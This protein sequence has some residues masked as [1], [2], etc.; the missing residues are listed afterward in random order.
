MSKGTTMLTAAPVEARPKGVEMPTPS[1]SFDRHPVVLS[2][3]SAML[4]WFSFLPTDWS[5][6]AWG[7]LVPL[8]LLIRSPRSR[9]SIYFGAWTGGMLFW[10]LAI[11]WV[12]LTDSDAWLAWL[13]MALALSVWWPGF[14]ML[15]R[16][17]VLRLGLP[18]MVA[19]PPIWVGLEYVR[20]HIFTGF[21]WYYLAHTQH[22]MLPLIQIADTTGALGVSL[23]LA[24]VNAWL[25]DLRTLPLSRSTPQGN[26]LSRPQLVRAGIVLGTLAATVGYGTFRIA[27]ARFREGPRLAL[28]QS[29]LEQ[30]RK[31]SEEPDQILLI[32]KSL[33]ERALRENTDLDL[34]VWPETAYPK[35]FVTRDPELSD[36]N[37]ERHARAYDETKGRDFWE[38]WDLD[39]RFR[40]HGW[41]DRIKVPMLVG[42][43]IYD[44]QA[45]GLAKLNS[46]ILFQPGVKAIQRYAKMHLVPFGEYVP[47]IDVFPW[48]T[49]LTPYRGASV[50]RLAFGTQPTWFNLGRYRVATAICFEDTIPQAVRRFFRGQADRQPDVVLNISNDG[51]FQGSSE[52]DMHLAISVFRAIENRVPMARAVNMGITAFIDGNGRVVASLAKK[53]EGVLSGTVPLD[54]RVSHYSEWGDW[55]G[56]ICLTFTVALIPVW[57]LQSFLSRRPA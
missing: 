57:V 4:L 8:F 13:V 20:A 56:A 52:H 27:T 17:S 47:L 9:R 48:L 33:V 24:L 42:S 5:W 22:Q 36:S 31:R 50:P 16:F 14:L 46:A 35:L 51:W 25:V 12:S 28:L 10:V 38:S 37:Y 41:T 54:D 7:A 18:L 53:T 55:L 34:I 43:V 39:T 15:A 29:N 26:R 40:M 23:I 11:Q 6:L 2:F 45:S 30:S 21:S 32:Y 1:L 19:A 44:F 3:F 49:V